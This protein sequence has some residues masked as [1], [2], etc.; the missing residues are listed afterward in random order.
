MIID[1]HSRFEQYFT[2]ATK[3]GSVILQAIIKGL[4][5]TPETARNILPNSHGILLIS[6]IIYSFII[7]NVGTEHGT[8][9]TNATRAFHYYDSALHTVICPPHQDLGLLTLIPS[10]FP[11]L[12]GLLLFMLFLE[13]KEMKSIISFT[14]LERSYL[15]FD[16]SYNNVCLVYSLCGS[17]GLGWESTH[18]SLDSTDIHSSFFYALPSTF[19][20]LLFLFIY[21][22]FL[23]FNFFSRLSPFLFLF[24]PP[25]FF[26]HTNIL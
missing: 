26:D 19:S 16:F 15:L 23:F 18:K 12:Q 20:L 8:V 4:G 13:R 25:L 5:G 2:E 6:H 14:N 3:A 21:H 1:L 7:I 22:Y 17:C 11:G 9:S 24:S 10:N